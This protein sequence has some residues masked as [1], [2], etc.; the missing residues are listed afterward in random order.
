MKCQTYFVKMI[1]SGAL[2]AMVFATAIN[3]LKISP[4]EFPRGNNPD[5]F[6]LWRTNSSCDCFFTYDPRAADE[7][8]FHTGGGME[9]S[10]T[11]MKTARTSKK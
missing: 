5:K 3:V 9:S 6:Y 2:L 1:L 10:P 11:L 8:L 4:V 7:W